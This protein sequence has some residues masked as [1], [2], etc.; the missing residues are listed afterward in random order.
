MAVEQWRELVASIWPANQV[1]NVLAVMECESGGNPEAHNTAGEDSRGLMQI[2]VY[3][4]PDMAGLNLYDPETNLRSALQIWQSSGWGPW[5]CAALRGN[6]VAN[7][8]PLPALA[9]A[10]ILA[11]LLLG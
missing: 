9:V 4:H 7:G 2:N 6:G 5:S 10:V 1:D 3:A 8:S 11:W